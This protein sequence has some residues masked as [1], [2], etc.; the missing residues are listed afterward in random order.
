MGRRIFCCLGLKG[1]GIAEGEI[2]IGDV[3]TE[4]RLFESGIDGH[5]HDLV[6]FGEGWREFVQERL[7]ARIAVGLE[8]DAQTLRL[9][10]ARH[11]ERAGDFGGM[12]RVVGEDVSLVVRWFG[13]CGIGEPCRTCRG[14]ENQKSPNPPITQSSN[15][16]SPTEGDRRTAR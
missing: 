9:E 11:G 13:G 5:Q 8:H 4:N 7:G 6:C 15:G 14:L 2:E 16:V 12:V 10:R 3:A 1:G